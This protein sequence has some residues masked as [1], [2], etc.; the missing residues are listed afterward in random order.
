MA[1][2]SRAE[3]AKQFMPFAAL[4]GYDDV[5]KQKERL[6]CDKRELTEE[7]IVELSKTVSEIK[8]GDIVKVT[9]Y[10]LDAYY[11]LIGAVT[12]IDLTLK[13]IAIIKT[14]IPFDDIL[15]IEFEENI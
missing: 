15:N 14:V 12:A 9:Y 8:K 2:M 3:R 1:K 11:T 5:V 13:Y 6:T 7:Q 4:R 10:K